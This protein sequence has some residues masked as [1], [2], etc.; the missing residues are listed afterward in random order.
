MSDGAVVRLSGGDAI[1]QG[2]RA[3]G[4]DTVFGL[5][6]VQ[7]Y[8]LFDALARAQLRVIGA[9]HE[10]GCGYMAY[11]YARSSGRPGVFCVV[12]GPGV[13]NAGA[14]LLT[15]ASTGTPVLCLTGQ[16][17]AAFIGLGQGHLHEMSDQLGTLRGIVKWAERIEDAACTPGLMERAFAE[18][19][20]GRPGPVALEMPWDVFTRVSSVR[21]RAPAGP[22]PPPPPD[23]ERIAEAARLLAAA[24]APMIFVG[25]GAFGAEAEIRELAE[26]LSAPVVSFRSGHGVLPADHP[27][28]L[29]IAAAR[30][31]WPET[32]VALGIGTRMEV[33]R[34]RW[35]GSPAGQKMLR[36]DIDAAQLRRIPTDLPILAAA[37]SGVRELLAALRRVCHTRR[38]R[39]ARIAAAK[40]QAE[41][42]IRSTQPQM[43]YLDVLRRVLPRNGFLTD[44]ICQA[45]FTSWFGFPIYE[46]RTLVP[47]GYQGNLGSGLGTALG[48]K[49]AHPD[50]KVVALAGDG[51]LM[52]AV[53]ELATAVQYG[54]AVVVLLFNNGAFGNVRRDQQQLFAG[55]AIASELVNPDFVALGRA[56]GVAS[57]RVAS[58][59]ALQPV[60][61]RALAEEQPWLIE[62]RVPRDAEAS[63]WRFI[64]PD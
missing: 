39:E 51:G 57:E 50:R 28:S 17:P 30:P 47:S 29:S 15:A 23:S 5:P 25:S 20:G 21:S 42:A 4:V 53:Q 26:L 3:Y 22:P 34:W 13:L 52:F 7:T 40:A 55:R 32:D 64:A 18:L 58:P 37:Q 63:P 36:M 54:I 38:D 48:V 31:L 19:R 43:A 49:V 60:L 45:G 46:P 56:F 10:Q 33:P 1:V 44:E 16:T 6:G 61:E 8:G 11:G 35:K 62:V 14:A 41:Q 24:T 2:L 59:E 12:P 27:L 9:R